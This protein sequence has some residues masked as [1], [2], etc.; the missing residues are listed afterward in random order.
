M[1]VPWVK[2]HVQTGRT[3]FLKLSYTWEEEYEQCWSQFHTDVLEGD[4]SGSGNA[5][6]GAAANADGQAVVGAAAAA[7]ATKQEEKKAKTKQ[8]SKAHGTS[9]AETG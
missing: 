6:P 9:A 3:M 8:T 4:V 7:T 1:G 5:L 2:V